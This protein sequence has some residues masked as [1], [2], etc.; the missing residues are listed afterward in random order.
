MIDK[1]RGV[2]RTKKNNKVTISTTSS[3]VREKGGEKG[4]E[5]L[6]FFQRK[7]EIKTRD[8]MEIQDTSI[9]LAN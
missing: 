9:L 3:N 2:R 4:G 5:F 1:N 6:F 7:R 8:E